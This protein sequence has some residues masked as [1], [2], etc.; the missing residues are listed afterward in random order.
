MTKPVKKQPDNNSDWLW[1]AAAIGREI[2]RT[3]DQVYYWFG[4]GMFR[5]AVW[6]MGRRNL[7]ASRQKLRELPALLAAETIERG[8]E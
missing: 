6:K 8:S 3:Q 4:R 5:D 2:N 1:G 7:V